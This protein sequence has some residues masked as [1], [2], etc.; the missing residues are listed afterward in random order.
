MEQD[1]NVPLQFGIRQ[2][3]GENGGPG[4]LFHSLRIIPPILEICE[5]ID[6]ICPDAIVFNFSNPMSR[7]CTTVHRRFPELTFVGMCHEIESISQ[8]LP[9]ILDTTWENLKTRCGGLNHFSILLEAI[10]P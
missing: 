1:W 4:G 5:D 10:L 3:M 9:L 2:S 8:H 6:A 7:I